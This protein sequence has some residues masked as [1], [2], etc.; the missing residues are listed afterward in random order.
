MRNTAVMSLISRS[1]LLDASAAS[2]AFHG[3]SC[4]A[5]ERRT[6]LRGR[7]EGRVTTGHWSDAV[8]TKLQP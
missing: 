8:N 5:H 2:G 1:A 4:R 3:E 6:L 7:V